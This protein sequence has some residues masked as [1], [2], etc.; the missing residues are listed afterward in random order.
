MKPVILLVD[1]EADLVGVLQDAIDLSMPDYQAVTSTSADDAED[2]LSRLPGELSL[3]CVDQRLGGRTGLEF[4]EDLR[5]RYPNVPSVL[6]TGQA[7]PRDEAR[8]R[9]VGVRVLWKPLRLSRWLFEIQQLL[10]A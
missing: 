4:I 10:A 8:A 2:V 3:V 7:S 6:F 1:D 9:Q 5:K